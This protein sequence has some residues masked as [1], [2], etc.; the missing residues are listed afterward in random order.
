M[1]AGDSAGCEK[2]RDDNYGKKEMTSVQKQLRTA[3]LIVFIWHR[4]LSCSPQ[5]VQSEIDYN[6]CQ[7]RLHR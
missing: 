3:L 7:F 4:Q 5:D 6:T 2:G 1:G